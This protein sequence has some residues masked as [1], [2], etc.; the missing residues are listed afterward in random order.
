M[1]AASLSLLALRPPHFV[2]ATRGD[3]ARPRRR[4]RWPPAVRPIFRR[5]NS[6]SFASSPNH[7][8]R[9]SAPAVRSD[10]GCREFMDL[11]M[12][13]QPERQVA[14]RGGPRVAR[15]RCQVRFDKSSRWLMRSA[16]RADTSRGR[17]REPE[18]THGWRS[19]TLRDLTARA[20]DTGMGTRSSVHGKR[21][22]REMEWMYDAALK[23]VAS[24]IRRMVSQW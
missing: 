17:R 13:D 20:S 12:I 18:F 11:L 24:A 21:F 8:R 23:S 4:P 6:G 22:R 7:H 2:G 10:A 14:M 16:T 19:S 3:E 1:S 15:S 5:L 9:T